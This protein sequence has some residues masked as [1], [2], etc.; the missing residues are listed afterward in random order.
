[1]RASRTENPSPLPRWRRVA[2][3]LGRVAL[4]AA[5]VGLLAGGWAYHSAR[6]QLGD[7]LFGLGT[8]MMAYEHATHQDAPRDLV[9]N[10]QTIHLSSGTTRRPAIEVLDWFEERCAAADGDLARQAAQLQAEHPE[11]DAPEQPL[12]P[13]LREDDGRNG[14]VACLDL[15][16][17]SVSVGELA[18]RIGRF[19]ETGDVSEIG[20]A[21]FVFAEQLGEGSETRTHF[22][23]LWTEGE[24]NVLRMFP[25]TGDAP[26]DDVD[27]VSRPP[28]ARRVLTGHERGM[29]HSITVYSTRLGEPELESFYRRD[30]AANGWTIL[31]TGAR[32]SD[33][34]PTLV[35]E[36][37]E[38]MV[39]LIFQPDPEGGGSQA[40][41]F[42]GR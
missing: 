9:V 15:G 12:S 7:Q 18:E 37:R 19:G 33:A 20:D 29:P 30:L 14:Y 36:R 13:T 28:R 1:M 26:G 16:A 4:V 25:E 39:T 32:P 5:F 21:R 11:I 2:R 34:P 27:G 41:I 31:E 10:G 24:L 22:V 8:Q 38:R 40:A 3:V 17:G 42:D 23:G 6:A 35:A